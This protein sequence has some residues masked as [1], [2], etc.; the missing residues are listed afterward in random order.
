MLDSWNKNAVLFEF[1]VLQWFPRVT[2]KDIAD[3]GRYFK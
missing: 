2:V 3:I 1:L